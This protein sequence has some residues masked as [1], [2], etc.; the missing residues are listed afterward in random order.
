MAR[1]GEP[2]FVDTGRC[3]TAKHSTSKPKTKKREIGK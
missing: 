2:F 1:S 3:G